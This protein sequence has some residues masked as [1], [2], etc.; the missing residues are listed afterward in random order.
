MGLSVKITK[1]IHLLLTYLDWGK[2]I[3]RMEPNTLSA[4]LPYLRSEQILRV[5]VRKTPE[6]SPE[7]I[8]KQTQRQWRMALFP[9]LLSSICRDRQNYTFTLTRSKSSSS[10]LQQLIASSICSDIRN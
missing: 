5:R 8:K 3:V 4:M 6:I 2:I 7:S 1:S 10:F 9:L